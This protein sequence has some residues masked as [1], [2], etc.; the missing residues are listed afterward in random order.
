MTSQNAPSER[1]TL[2]RGVGNAEYD[3]N[4]IK[5]ILK[6]GLVAHV[7]VTTDSGPIVLPMAYGVDGDQLL[8]HG[9][10]ANAMMR[11][12]SGLDVCVTVTIVDGLVVGRTPLHNS[13]NYR[14]VVVRGK[15]QPIKEPTAHKAAL[16]VI[17][18]HVAPIWDTARPPSDGDLKRTMVLSVPLIE[19]SAKIRQGG[20]IDEPQDLDGPHWAGVVSIQSAWS[21]PVNSEDLA[22]DI[23]VPEALRALAGRDP[24]REGG[25][26]Q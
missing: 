24:Y 13:M 20:P 9:S 17:N 15:A 4:A 23:E 2:R 21:N 22:N 26:S 10:V 6:V 7:G 12:G 16:K 25:G 19:A 18:D 1:T 8:L 14:S 5:A 3:A 11:A